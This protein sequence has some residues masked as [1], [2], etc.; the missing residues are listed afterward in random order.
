MIVLLDVG[1]PREGKSNYA[2]A[3]ICSGANKKKPCYVY[4][5]KNEYGPKYETW[6]DGNR[7]TV[8][9]P[10][11]IAND[12]TQFRSRY[13]G[14]AKGIDPDYFLFILLQKRNSIIVVDE[15]TSVLKGMLSKD[16]NNVLT[17][18]AHS[19]N[20]FIFIFHSL[21]TI[22]PDFIRNSS[23]DQIVLFKTMDNYQDIKSKFGSELLNMGFQ[24]QYKKQRKS[25]PTI[26]DFTE[27]KINNQQINF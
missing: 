26:I 9:G 15:A 20:S 17:G 3:L 2:K 12:P 14:N 24:M 4:D 1:G 25:P 23:C 16:W 10:G 27:G 19:G 6:I 21:T 8:P 11:L 13:V 18:R 7:A 22:P 5:P